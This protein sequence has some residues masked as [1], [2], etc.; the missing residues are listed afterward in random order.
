MFEPYPW[1]KKII[2]APQRFK[3]LLI[4]RKA[5]KTTL[6]INELIRWAR[7]VPNKI[8]CYVGPILKQA[9]DTV[10]KDPEMIFKYVHPSMLDTSKAN[11]GKNEAET[12]LYFK[13]G[14]I[15][16]VRGADDPDSLRGPNFFF[17]V[18]DEFALMDPAVWYEVLRPVMSVKKDAHCWFIGTPKPQGTHFK[19]IFEQAQDAEDWFAIKMTIDDTNLVSQKEIE[20]AKKEGMTELAIRQEFYCE[21]VESMG[22]IF[23]NI[24]EVCKGKIKDYNKF[25][26]YR[27]GVDLGRLTSETAISVFDLSTFEQVL[28]D[29]W[30]NVDWHLTIQRLKA[31]QQRFGG[32]ELIC[33]ITGVGD[34]VVET[35]EREGLRLWQDNNGRKGFYFT[36]STKKN[37]I[38]NLAY[39]MEE[40]KI[41]LLN[42]PTLK[43]QLS[44]YGWE[45]TKA[46]NVRYGSP[47]GEKDDIVH[48][49]AL[50]VWE[51]PSQ[52]N[53][54]NVENQSYINP[55][56]IYK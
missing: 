45:I 25:H 46:G 2:L 52:P 49:T 35:L 31:Y 5:G 48:A 8:F 28:I 14:S 39:L 42:D 34:P 10:W 36:L 37:L 50:S 6:A 24:E 17:V 16:Q 38:D 3:V 43:K 30:Q 47:Q 51:L 26:L 19:K 13:S 23:R 44:I 29:S 22:I 4:H 33:D 41:T 12:T 56:R 21:F 32:A 54:F 11:K 1:Q 7:V 18:L 20:E 40:R 27:I 9:K 55:V 15:L 53:T